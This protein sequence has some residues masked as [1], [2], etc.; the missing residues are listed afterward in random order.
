MQKGNVKLAAVATVVIVIVLLFSWQY[1]APE[2]DGP[3]S[4][5][6]DALAGGAAA[7]HTTPWLRS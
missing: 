2:D 7:Q 1:T 4:D 3:S 5:F 6:A